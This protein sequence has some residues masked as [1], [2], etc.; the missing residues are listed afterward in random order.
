MDGEAPAPQSWDMLHRAIDQDAAED[1]LTDQDVWHAWKLGLA[2]FKAGR[3][4]GILGRQAEPEVP[5][6]PIQ[7]DFG[8]DI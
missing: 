4:I 6:G 8:R 3:D 7:D 5:E 1:G 2:A